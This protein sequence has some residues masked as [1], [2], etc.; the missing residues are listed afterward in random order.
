MN[1]KQDPDSKSQAPGSD[2]QGSSSKSIPPDADSV[3][4]GLNL[5][6]NAAEIAGETVAVVGE[7]TGQFQR[8]PSVERGER[9]STGKSAFLVGAGILISRIIG[10]IRQRVFGH[11]FG[12]SLAADAFNAAFRIPNFL[13]NV[14][15][16]GALSASFIPVYA[17]LLARKDE[18]EASRVASAVLTVLALVTAVIVLLGV[19]GTPYIVTIVAWGFVSERRELT[20]RLVQIFFPGAGLLVMSAWCLGVL[21]SH[22]KF[23]LSYTAPVVWNLAIIASLILFGSHSGN[24][25]GVQLG[26]F[27]SRL[28]ILTAWGSVIGS[29]L[30]FVVQL[31]TVLWLVRGLRPVFDFANANVRTVLRNFF[32]VFMSRGVVQISAFIDAGLASLVP[33]IGAVSALGYAQSLYTLPVSLFGMSVSAAELPA[34]SSALG[35]SDEIADQLR[36]RLDGGLRRIAFFIVPSAMAMLALGDVMTAALYQTGQFKHADSR[37]VWGILAGS[38]IGLL[39]STLG[40]L[41]ASTYYALHDTRTPLRYAII[42][43]TLTTVLG[44]LFAIPLPPAIGLDP[45]WGVAGL[46]A[47]AGIAGWI[48]FALLRR[49]LN[50]RIGRTGLPLTY[51]VKLWLAAAAGAGAGWA[52]KL[53]LGAYHPAIIA[54]L[55]LLPYGLIYFAVTAV[56]RVPE[57]NAVLGRVLKLGRRRR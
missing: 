11:Y 33:Y 9:E 24:L 43:V 56:F 39:A 57:L 31:P 26:A 54:G 30:Q 6:R 2:S 7:A 22:R 37:Y 21:N 3:R 18:K 8:P 42:R 45:K 34:M 17:N 50:R 25:E 12:V 16:E 10:V 44:Y 20:I 14:F 41:Y 52:I 15:G 32:P 4:E 38:T 1:D 53:Y 48:E 46:T 27:Q 28:A 40:R 5:R 35:T 19:L 29:A 49:T 36:R 13:Q 51:V 47:S 23:L 55:V